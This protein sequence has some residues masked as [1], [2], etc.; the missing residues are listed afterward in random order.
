MV[1]L[2]PFEVQLPLLILSWVIF[3][4][5]I[6]TCCVSM[7]ILHMLSFPF[8]KILS[9]IFIFFHLHKEKTPRTEN[10]KGIF[11]QNLMVF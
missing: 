11:K 8:K 10:L 6:C 4:C 1:A 2:G 9:I 3:F 7:L 5:D